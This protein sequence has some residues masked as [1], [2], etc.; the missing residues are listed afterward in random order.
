MNGIFQAKAVEVTVL[1]D[2]RM[3][4]KNAASYLGLSPKTLAMMRCE[5]TGPKFVKRGRVFY[6]KHDLDAWIAD[7]R[8]IST[9]Q[10]V[11]QK[12]MHMGGAGV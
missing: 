5:G 7:G 12:S 4:A 11:V 9:T 10:A 2:G 8:F 3:D 1:P 6:F